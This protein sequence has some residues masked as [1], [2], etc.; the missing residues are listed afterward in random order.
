MD[1]L[2]THTTIRHKRKHPKNQIIANG[3]KNYFSK[4]VAIERISLLGISM[5]RDRL[6]S[7]PSG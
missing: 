7:R 6:T 3:S 4:L 5:G 2:L 1:E